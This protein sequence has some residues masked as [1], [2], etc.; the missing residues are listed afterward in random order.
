MTDDFQPYKGSLLDRIERAKAR[1]VAYPEGVTG[2]T[3]RNGTPG[4]ARLQAMFRPA[5]RYEPPYAPADEGPLQAV[6]VAD[7][8]DAAL[9]KEGRR[10]LELRQ[11][12]NAL[13]K[14]ASAFHREHTWHDHQSLVRCQH[15]LCAANMKLLGFSEVT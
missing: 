10:L 14:T 5:Y 4:P 8:A 13:S 7:E 11:L 9:A 2:W 6:S 1:G 3:P 12:R 15:P